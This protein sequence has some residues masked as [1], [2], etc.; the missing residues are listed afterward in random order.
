LKWP[1]DV[2]IEEK[3]VCGTLIEVENDYMLIGI[4]C[5]V[6][7]APEVCTLNHM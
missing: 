4:G 6:V 3:K 1:N 5:N 7:T 2:L